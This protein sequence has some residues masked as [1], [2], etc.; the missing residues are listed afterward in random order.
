[1]KRFAC[2]ILVLLAASCVEPR[3]VPIRATR[4]VASDARARRVDSRPAVD[5]S[6]AGANVLATRESADARTAVAAPEAARVP[7]AD[8]ATA[9]NPSPATCTPSPARVAVTSIPL[10]R[11]PGP[12][13][14]PDPVGVA[15]HEMLPVWDDSLG[16]RPAA[17]V[18][19]WGEN[20]IV[21]NLYDP[22]RA[23]PQQIEFSLD[24]GPWVAARYGRV[25]VPD[26][27]VGTYQVRCVAY[28]ANGRSWVMK[29]LILERTATGWRTK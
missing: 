26:L 4:G 2:T 23:T 20:E 22:P 16:P 13:R 28:P 14:Q 10:A 25:I 24:G 1:M 21:L 18:L 17:V 8:S 9:P 15:D 11:G 29:P 7:P 12:A 3:I 27:G 6:V 19:A 5:D